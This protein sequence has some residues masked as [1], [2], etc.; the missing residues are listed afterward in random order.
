MAASARY[1]NLTERKKELQNTLL[2]ERFRKEIHSSPCLKAGVSWIYAMNLPRRR[3]GLHSVRA[4]LLLWN[5]GIVALVLAAMGGLISYSVR[6]NLM[7][8]VI[9]T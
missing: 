1:V 3:I 4:R 5:A 6:A 2:R 9:A 7:A 8:S